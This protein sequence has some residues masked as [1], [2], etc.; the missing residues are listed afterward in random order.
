MEALQHAR[1]LA[2]FVS[3]IRTPRLIDVF[4]VRTVLQ[5]NLHLV[6]RTNRHQQIA[7][8]LQIRLPLLTETFGKICT[9]RFAGS[10]N[11]IGE[12]T[13]LFDLGKLQRRLMQVERNSIRS[14]EHFEILDG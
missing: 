12:T 10:P 6:R 11:L 3:P 13:K 2:I 5:P 9:D 7:L 8:E 14:P 1:D 4:K